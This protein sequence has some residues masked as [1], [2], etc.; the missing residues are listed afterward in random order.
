MSVNAVCNY[1]KFNFVKCDE[2]LNHHSHDTRQGNTEPSDGGDC[3][4][5]GHLFGAGC[6]LEESSLSTSPGSAD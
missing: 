2:H 1:Q 6:Y 3:V 5:L 4:S